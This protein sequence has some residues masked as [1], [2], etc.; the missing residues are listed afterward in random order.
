VC[1]CLPTTEP[2]SRARSNCTVAVD[3]ET[4]LLDSKTSG[5]YRAV[6]RV[7]EWFPEEE[8]FAWSQIE[9]LLAT[10]EAAHIQVHSHSQRHGFRSE[11]TLVRRETNDPPPTSDYQLT[12]QCA[13][14]TVRHRSR[15][16]CIGPRE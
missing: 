10:C 5:R 7:L 3:F 4:G 12:S 14:R 13:Q 1:G 6:I 8:T 11:R 16:L 9:D 15:L 2:F